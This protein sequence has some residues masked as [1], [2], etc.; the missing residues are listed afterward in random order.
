MRIGWLSLG[1]FFVG[2]AVAAETAFDL[3]PGTRVLNP[4]VFRQLAVFP[5][6]QTTQQT[7]AP[8][9]FLTLSDGLKSK[10]VEVHELGRGGQ[11]NQVRVKNKSGKPLLM[12]AGEVILGGQQDRILGKDTIVPAAEESTVQVFCVEHGR[13]SGQTGFAGT[14]GFAS[15]KIKLRATHRSDQGQVWNEV[16]E[17]NA[18][19]GVR[20]PTGTYR[21]LA[22]GSAGEKAVQ[23]Y[24]DH[25][26]AA[27]DRLPDKEKMV[28]IISAL[29]G[30]V[31]SV[32]IF[33]SPPLFAQYRSRLLDALFVSAA[34]LPVPSQ[35]APMPEAAAIRSFM[36][37]AD[38]APAQVVDD[39]ALS[40]TEHSGAKTVVKSELK[41]K[42]PGKAIYK[43]Y[44]RNE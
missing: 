12:L 36:N 11:V 37:E 13:W 8:E 44:L 4:I 33:A 34:D 31:T 23:P 41:P 25:I 22:A 20:N 27:L 3:E 39:K 15:T 2:N 26:A 5:V 9:Q 35:P 1:M 29:N 18:S 10:Q 42:A 7:T 40:R 19:L 30:R 16:A 6:V 43:S 24:R 14:G 28:G 17:K 38:A 21:D 32:D